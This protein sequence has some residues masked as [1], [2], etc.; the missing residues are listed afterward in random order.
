MLID[1]AQGAGGEDMSQAKVNGTVTTGEDYDAVVVGASLAGCASAILLARDGARVALVE[2]RPDQAAYKK[3]C[4]HYIQSSAVASLE[5]LGLL[6]PMMQAGAVRSRVRLNTPW[7]WIEPPTESLVPS[8]VNL[9]REILDPMIRETAANTPGVELIL[10]HT[11]HELLRDGDVVC[12][13]LARNTAGEEL[14]LKSRLLVGADGRG[15]RIAKLAGVASKTVPHG[16]I[17]YGGYFEG[18]PPQ[19]SP[20]ASFWLLDPDMA[21]AF[22]TDSGLTFY[23]A[24]PVKEHAGAFREDPGNALVA[25]LEGLPD[26]PPIRASRMVQPPQGK[27]DMTNVAN[28]PVAP[29]LALVGDAA[30]AIDPLWGVGCG[31]ALQSAGWLADSVSPALRGSEPLPAAL[32]RYRRRHA[33]ALRGH[34]AMIYDY[35]GGRKFNA[36]ERLLF[37]TATY[38]DRMAA[39]MEAFGTR[40]MGPLQMMMRGMPLALRARARRSL[41]RRGGRRSGSTPVGSAVG[42]GPVVQGSSTRAAR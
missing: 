2:Q 8:G 26:G 25:L 18:P 7:G 21:A 14:R 11:V 35:A 41:S 12:G 6:E 23:A 29:G 24:M 38:D 19:G 13:A 37:S 22:P 3:I 42:D 40:N 39:V 36:P 33:R 34:A 9:R 5:R 20:D 28:E 27:L 32:K 17:A 30:L 10:G 16:R 31:W 1:Q 4:S 15:S